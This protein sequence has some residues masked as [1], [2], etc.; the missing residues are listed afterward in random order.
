MTDIRSLLAPYQQMGYKVLFVSAGENTGLD[1]LRAALT[2]K[3]SVFAGPSGVGKSTLLNALDKNLNLATGSISE[4]I[5][6]GK[7]TTR[8]A[9]LMPFSGGGFV[10]DTPGFSATE[11]THIDQKN[12]AAC[13]AE[14]RPFLGQCKY[15]TCSHD[16]EPQCAIKNAVATGMIS[17]DRYTA[18]L[19]ILREIQNIKRGF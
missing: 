4:K 16:H 19:N 1:E 7:H 3:I 18:Y 2:D 10:V 14:F 8:L 13:F 9:Q 6:R 15:S 11:F 17:A 5:K 12:L